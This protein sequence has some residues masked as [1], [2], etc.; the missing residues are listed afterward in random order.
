MDCLDFPEILLCHKCLDSFRH[1]SDNKILSEISHYPVM[2]KLW[3]RDLL[4][5]RITQNVNN[6]LSDTAG[7]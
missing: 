3:D 6:I 2:D 4:P 5:I 7:P 1:T